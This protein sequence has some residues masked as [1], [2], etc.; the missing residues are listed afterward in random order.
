MVFEPAS[1]KE[2]TER[3]PAA[4]AMLRHQLVDHPLLTIE[5]LVELARSLPAVSVEYNSGELPIGQDPA[6]TPMNGLSAEETV[7]RIAENKSWIV[8]KKVEQDGE[9][10]ALLN[11]CLSATAPVASAATGAMHKREAFIFVSSPGSVTPFHMDPEHNILF[12]ISGAKTFNIFPSNTAEIVSDEDHEEFHI[13]GA[14]RNLPYK[15]EYARFG[16][17]MN[18]APGDALYVPV[19]SPHWVKVGPEV[20]VSLSITWR[21]EASDS[22][23]H[24]RRANGW[25]RA[26]GLAPSTP[27]ASPLRDRAAILAARLAARMSRR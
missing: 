23:A 20:S 21:S 13:D 12:Q 1:L 25:L 27:G 6:Q 5:R 24:L 18:M 3:Y 15:D 9:Y 19:K 7:R 14:H 16:A 4:P 2:F 17:A 8:L 22:E 10:A 26:R 11:E